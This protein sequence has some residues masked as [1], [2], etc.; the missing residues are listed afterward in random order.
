MKLWHLS[1]VLA[2]L[3]VS[4]GATFAANS[5]SFGNDDR[6][7][8]AY[9]EPGTD[10]ANQVMCGNWSDR[11]EDLARDAKEPVLWFER[12]GQ[13]YVVR[14]ATYTSRAHTVV[15]P[16]MDLGRE[17]GRLGAKQ[18]RLGAEQGKIGAR[19]GALGARMGAISAREVVAKL[20]GRDTDDLRNERESVRRDMEDLRR[21]QEP[22]A[23]KQRDLGA[24]QR[25]LGKKQRDASHKAEAEMERILDDAIRAGAASRFANLDD[26]IY[27]L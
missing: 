5:I 11:V 12:D 21:Q 4:A 26:G 16:M 15:Q 25:E 9:I 22:L 18:G 1:P 13:E 3:V 24:K 17:Q 10:G 20:D 8:Y 14:G 23:D 7:Q 2:F 27:T 19:M 6:F